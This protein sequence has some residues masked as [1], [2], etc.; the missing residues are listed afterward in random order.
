MNNDTNKNINSKVTKKD[1]WKN[2]PHAEWDDTTWD[3]HRKDEG[4]KH[5]QN[6]TH[7]GYK[8]NSNSFL[9]TTPTKH[10]ENKG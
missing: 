1:D 2:L 6:A 5:V 10:W 3:K 4:W 8:R 9:N 7:A